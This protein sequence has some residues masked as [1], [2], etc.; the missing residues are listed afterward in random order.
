MGRASDPARIPEFILTGAA[1]YLTGTWDVGKTR[2]GRLPLQKESAHS[3]NWK[4][5]LER[6]GWIGY[7]IPLALK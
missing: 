7:G 5:D 2:V 1:I 6:I 3:I 4:F